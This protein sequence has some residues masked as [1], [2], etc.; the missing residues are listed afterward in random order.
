M[1]P[2]ALRV[3]ETRSAQPVTVRVFLDMLGLGHLVPT[4]ESEGL[5][6]ASDFEPFRR[7]HTR[8]FVLSTMFGAGLINL[9][10]ISI[11]DDAFERNGDT[12]TGVILLGH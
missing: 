8:R 3:F 9:M 5:Q 2:V 11:V 10:D 12:P 4:F 6:S 1:Q 7:Q